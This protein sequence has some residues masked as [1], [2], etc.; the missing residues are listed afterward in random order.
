MRRTRCAALLLGLVFGLPGARLEAAAVSVYAAISLSE[1]LQ[2]IATAQEAITGD[3]VIF[4]FASSSTLALQIE[5]GARADIF[6]SADEAKMDGLEKK[7]LLEPGTRTSLL[8]NTLVLVVSADSRLA[9][10]APRDLAKPEV[11]HLAL[12]DPQI[13]PAGLYAREFLTKVG[14]WKQVQSKILPTENVRAALAAVESG[15]V[16][17]AIVYETD[18]CISKKV[19][20]AYRVPATEGPRI[21]YPV[22]VLQGSVHP[23]AARSFVNHLQSA[24]ALEM[25]RKRGFVV[26]VPPR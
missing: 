8:S 14:L 16:D 21:S 10:A 7:K 25:F 19:R 15:N 1:A 3:R 20:I 5:A 24:A 13:V 9:I 22:A 12:A 23:I 17:A 6:F 2:E 26:L 18:A 4:N 11:A